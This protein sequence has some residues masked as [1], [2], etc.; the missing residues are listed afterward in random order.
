AYI[1]HGVLSEGAA[2]RVAASKLKELVITNSIEETED[3]KAAKNIR[4]IS[5]APLMGEAIART[6]SEQSVSSLLD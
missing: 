2:A 1:T 5:I 6:A 4:C 3:V